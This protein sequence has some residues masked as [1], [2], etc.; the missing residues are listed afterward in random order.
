MTMAGICACVIA[1]IYSYRVH[2]IGSISVSVYTIEQDRTS[3][4]K[5]A[6]NDVTSEM[7]T[8]TL[9]RRPGAQRLEDPRPAAH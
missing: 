2:R 6:T 1:V 7:Q 5:P 4:S 9:G 3:S 8:A